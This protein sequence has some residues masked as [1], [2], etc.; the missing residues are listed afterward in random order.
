VTPRRA[1]VAGVVT[2]VLLLVGLFAARRETGPALTPEEALAADADPGIAVAPFAVNDP[3]LNSL[4]KDMVVLLSTNL[5]GV[6]GLRAISSRTML[7]RWEE[8]ARGTT[9]PDEAAS[10]AIAGDTGARYGVIGSA[11][12]IGAEV[13]LTA[14]VFE[15]RSRKRLGS[16]RAQGSVDDLWTLVDRLSIEIIKVI[17]GG[18]E[19]APQIRGLASVT[20]DSL[21]ALKAYLRGEELY[22]RGS[23][24]GAATEFVRAVEIDS[25]FALA[26]L[27]LLR[28]CGWITSRSACEAAGARVSRFV[29][30]LPEREAAYFRAGFLE[31]GSLDQLE[32]VRANVRRYPDDPE[33][34]FQLGDWYYHHGGE[35]FIDPGESSKA[36][37]RSI[38]LAP[39]SAP[40]D[41]YIHVIEA[42][43]QA[44]D[45]ARLAE[46]IQT[47]GRYTPGGDWLRAF[48]LTYV[49]AFGDSAE[50]G[51]ARLEIAAL[52]PDYAWAPASALA[53]P[54]FLPLSV[55]LFAELF[56]REDLDEEG[57]SIVV[58][59]YVERLIARGQL[60]SALVHLNG[61]AFHPEFR[62][63][64]AYRLHQIGMT[65]PPDWV[66]VDGTDEILF[67]PLFYAGAYAADQDRWSDHRRIV[68]KLR[69]HGRQEHPA[70]AFD[71]GIE[72]ML[73]DSLAARYHQDA[74][75]ALE[76]YAL[77]RRG[78]AQEAERI[79]QA[80]QRRMVGLIQIT[81]VN[82]T[83]RGWLAEIAVE[84]G[85]WREAARYYRSLQGDLG[86]GAMANA[87]Y[88]AYELGRVYTR[89]G[90][91]GNARESYEYALLAWR[92]A[93]PV[94][95]P[96]IESARREIARLRRAG[97]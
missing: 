71:F 50:A 13:L 80:Q 53:H 58:Y 55:E 19:E 16:A 54:R 29:D 36:F 37:A 78:N 5:D 40:L 39:G 33:A 48:R 31:N 95:Q 66:S 21:E 25:T 77:W 85:D 1:F 61:P 18:E 2:A 81:Q 41:A 43:F 92:N 82:R 96:R 4:R 12:R 47:A 20:T 65:L 22:R 88:A 60:R 74:A 34:W 7:A 79:L 70:E 76:A 10:L 86:P 75:L 3:G 14:D 44:A 26:A 38:A 15:I 23:F 68:E 6:A 69:A 24:E 30:R 49:L 91:R 83:L 90:D 28:A 57:A 59:F 9:N 46:W 8:R 56:A 97:E 35:A 52:D 51:R 84:T 42:S 11:V 72:Q 62:G 27:Q 64:M 89:L 94:L 87:P 17:K 73:V 63:A 32:L 93:D 45:S 67:L